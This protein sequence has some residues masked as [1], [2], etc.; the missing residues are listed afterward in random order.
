VA[1]ADGV[2]AANAISVTLHN[3]PR[4]SLPRDQS[5]RARCLAALSWTRAK[6][7]IPRGRPQRHSSGEEEAT[8]GLRGTCELLGEFRT[9]GS[10]AL[11][12]DHRVRVLREPLVYCFLDRILLRTAAILTHGKPGMSC[13]EAEGTGASGASFANAAYIFA[14]AA[15][16]V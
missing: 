3:L 11:L 7:A 2:G 8:K 5:G 14:I 4:Q 13:S 10:A 9:C 6:L 16:Q 12:I 1:S 15:I